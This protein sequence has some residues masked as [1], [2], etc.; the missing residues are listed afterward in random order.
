MNKY[1]IKYFTKESTIQNNNDLPYVRCPDPLKHF[2]IKEISLLQTLEP[3]KGLKFYHLINKNESESD[4][5]C[6]AVKEYLRSQTALK[7]EIF[8]QPST[9]SYVSPVQ[10]SLE[11][12][13]SS[14][15]YETHDN[16]QAHCSTDNEPIISDQESVI[17][18]SS[19]SPNVSDYDVGSESDSWNLF[20]KLFYFIKICIQ[21]W[22]Q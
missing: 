13:S 11:R 5:D 15:D 4:D 12:P 18:P 7:T 10:N 22:F 20:F 8:D 21:E 17:N 19:P 16:S 1:I 14:M 6:E 3:R 9:S 2:D